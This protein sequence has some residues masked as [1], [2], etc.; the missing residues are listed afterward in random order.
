MPK[1][2]KKKQR[3]PKEIPK[4]KT[5]KYI[6]AHFKHSDVKYAVEF[7]QKQIR[8][9]L[10]N[11]E[12][13]GVY[14][15]RVYFSKSSESVYVAFTLSPEAQRAV[16][17][18]EKIYMGQFV[19]SSHK[20]YYTMNVR[21]FYLQ[22]VSS[23]DEFENYLRGKIKELISQ[24]VRPQSFLCTLTKKEL[25]CLRVIGKSLRTGTYLELDPNQIGDP[26]FDIC[27]RTKTRALLAVT[28]E[29]KT[30]QMVGNLQ[31]KGCLQV[32]N[33]AVGYR[34]GLSLSNTGKALLGTYGA[35]IESSTWIKY[36]DT[37][38]LDL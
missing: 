26:L 22:D 23:A 12:E 1:K 25:D 18:S 20:R 33:N 31:Y 34:L 16:G 15:E 29:E 21:T 28:R 6:D 4:Q 36:L 8:R 32:V 11:L 13:I 10:T 38:S 2:K 19:I 24:E 30:S 7:Y 17:V 3:Q 14:T 27:F 5:R 37:R 35:D 9:M